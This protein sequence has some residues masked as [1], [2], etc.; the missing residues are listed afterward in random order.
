MCRLPSSGR[1]RR[2][3]CGLPYP[4]SGR[5]SRPCVALHVGFLTGAPRRRRPGRCS[6]FH[7]PI[8]P[9]SS[10]VRRGGG[11]GGDSRTR[12]PGA[13]GHCAFPVAL[14]RTLP[15]AILVAP[16][17][18]MLIVRRRR[19]GPVIG[20]E[21][22]RVRPVIAPSPLRTPAGDPTP[23]TQ[24]KVRTRPKSTTGFSLSKA[25]PGFKSGY[26]F[27]GCRLTSLVITNIS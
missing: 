3:A 13:N 5:R 16:L 8:P 2:W 11:R 19:W 1:V 18:T 17:P 12:R 24:V 10:G 25:V 4:A 22:R 9:A 26:R 15:P 14:P 7:A 6:P 27:S 21:R 20:R 23:I